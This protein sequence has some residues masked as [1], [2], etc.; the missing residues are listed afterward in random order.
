MR[1]FHFNLI[2]IT[3]SILSAGCASNLKLVDTMETGYGNARFYSNKTNNKDDVKWILASVDSADIKSF[4]T[5]FPKE[6]IKKTESS[7]QLIY[8]VSYEPIPESINQN[9]YERFSPL[10]SIIL[11][12]GDDIL[13]SLGLDNFQRFNGARSFIIEINYY[14]GYP[15]CKLP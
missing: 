6:I 4:Y 2:F 11:T 15:K 7:R 9:N 3:I 14:H 12:K 10:D 5:F 1:P 8:T 13:T